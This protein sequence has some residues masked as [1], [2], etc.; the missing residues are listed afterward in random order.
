M[1]LVLGGLQMSQCLVYIDDV[2]VIERTFDEH[3]CNLQEVSEQVRGTG[4]KLKPSKCAFLQERVF[5]LGHEVSKKGS[6]YRSH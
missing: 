3:L 6:G 1:D 5:Y 4:L 2:I